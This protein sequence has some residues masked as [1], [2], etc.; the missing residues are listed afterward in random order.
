VHALGVRVGKY[1]LRKFGNKD[2]KTHDEIWKHT[3][4]RRLSLLP[5]PIGL[6]LNFEKS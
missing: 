5:Y 3:S 6:K 4:S 1:L 2:I